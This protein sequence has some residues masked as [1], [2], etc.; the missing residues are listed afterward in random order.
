MNEKELLLN[1]INEKK[2]QLASSRKGTESWSS[3]GKKKLGTSQASKLSVQALE[4][5]IKNL[6]EELR[7]LQ[8]NQTQT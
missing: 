7:I 3:R 4:K 8:N 1:S 6:S 5:E 2:A